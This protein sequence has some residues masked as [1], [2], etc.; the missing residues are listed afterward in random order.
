VPGC[1][2]AA[3]QAP[4]VTFSPNIA[5]DFPPKMPKIVILNGFDADLYSNNGRLKQWNFSAFQKK[6]AYDRR[7][8]NTGRTHDRWAVNNSNSS[9]WDRLA[10][11][12]KKNYQKH[13]R[14][15]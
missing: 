3:L 7:L 15:T 2:K 1:C 5:I 11:G 4:L 10:E 14:K 13:H 6:S 12:Q 9:A 8:V